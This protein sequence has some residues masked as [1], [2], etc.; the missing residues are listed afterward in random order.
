[1]QR[2]KPPMQ[3]LEESGA[4]VH[5]LT[6]RKQ[7]AF[8]TDLVKAKRARKETGHHIV[9]FNGRSLRE[10]GEYGEE[11]AEETL[12]GAFRSE[13][14]SEP[15]YE[16][17]ASH[18]CLPKFDNNNRKTDIQ[19]ESKRQT[20]EETDALREGI[21][22]MVRGRMEKGESSMEQDLGD[23]SARAS[24][25]ATMMPSSEAAAETKGKKGKMVVEYEDFFGEEKGRFR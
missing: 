2:I 24:K 8:K 9:K 1:M 10:R 20:V 22:Q 19:K 21:R 13:G 11:R 18:Y 16:R 3:Y 5:V 17:D 15:C 6:E 25:R 14:G 7:K 12:E 23:H 4:D